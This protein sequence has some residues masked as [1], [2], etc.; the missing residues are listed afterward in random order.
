MVLPHIPICM[1]TVKLYGMFVESTTIAGW[2]KISLP[3][4]GQYYEPADGWGG[5]LKEDVMD[6]FCL[7]RR[8]WRKTLSNVSHFLSVSFRINSRSEIN[9]IQPVHR[10]FFLFAV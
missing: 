5:A 4:S 10:N 7:D 8:R 3:P 2:L 6:A 9:G 1:T